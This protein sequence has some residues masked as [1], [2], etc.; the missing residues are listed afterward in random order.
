VELGEKRKVSRTADDGNES[1]DTET[2]AKFDWENKKKS[3]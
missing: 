2:I 1:A 3:A